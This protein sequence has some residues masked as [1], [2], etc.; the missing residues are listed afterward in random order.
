MNIILI[1]ENLKAIKT[2]LLLSTD[3]SLPLLELKKKTKLANLYFFKALEHLENEGIIERVK[4]E[5][6]TLIILRESSC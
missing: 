4:D 2:A 5:D 3:H 6:E 1:N